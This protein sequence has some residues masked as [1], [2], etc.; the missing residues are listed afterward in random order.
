MCFVNAGLGVQRKI[1]VEPGLFE[2]LGWYRSGLPNF[3]S[4]PELV[5]C[6]FNIDV[7]YEVVW[8][9]TKYDRN[10]KAEQYYQRCHEVTKEI[11]CRHEVEG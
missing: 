4:M 7:N 5:D 11:L 8:P 3:M 2:W 6:G 1:H 10:E 9:F